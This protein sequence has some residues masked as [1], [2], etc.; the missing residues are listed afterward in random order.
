[1][2]IVT[3]QQMRQLEEATVAAGATWPGLMEQAGWGVAQEILRLRGLGPENHVLI[4]VGPGNNGGDALVVA[5]HLHDANLQVTLYIWRRNQDQSDLN[6]ERCRNRAI[7][8]IFL[9]QDTHYAE[10]RRLLSQATLVVDGMLGMGTTRLVSGELAEIIASVNALRAERKPAQAPNEPPQPLIVSIDLP[11]GINSDTG[12]VLGSALRAD[13]TIATGVAKQGLFFYPGTEYAGDLA[14]AEIGVPPA[15]LEAVMSETLTT[16]LARKLLPARPE[17]SHKGTFG[18]ALIVAGSLR[19]PGA[20]SLASA[21]A[22]RAGAGLV[23]LAT[24]RS[25]IGAGRIPEVTLLPLPEADFGTLGEAA[26]GKLLEDMK[27]YTSLLIGPGLGHE[28][29]TALFFKRLLGLESSNKKRGRV[30]FRLGAEEEA[31]ALASNERPELPSLVIDA[32]GLNILAQIENWHELLPEGRAVLTPHPGEMLR[33]LKSEDLGDD[34]IELAR[35]SAK[36]WGQILILKGSTTVIAA[37]DGRV[38]VHKQG[39]PALAT[40]GTG[41]VLAGTIVALL[42]QKLAPFDAAVLGVYLHGAAGALV[43]E[44]FGDMGAIASD[45]LPKLPKAAKALRESA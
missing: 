6:W 15:Q 42:A 21:A 13:L 18:K 40:A 39:N 27:G 37:P 30:G 3:T 43:R 2:R 25:I 22:A 23:T 36:R 8:T 7:P 4:L 45:L 14:L 33:L 35:E 9:S 34:P 38:V 17:D 16:D 20:A 26:A 19:Y 44:E 29:P 12:Q 10:L 31:S 32:D 1:M 41:D 28:E 24:G 11:T 5:R